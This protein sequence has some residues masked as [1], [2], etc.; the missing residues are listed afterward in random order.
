M[1][2][3]RYIKFLL[4]YLLIVLSVGCDSN[5]IPENVKE[6][7]TNLS[8]SSGFAISG[9]V[10]NK[11]GQIITDST[12]RILAD[13]RS[14]KSVRLNPDGKFFFQGLGKRTYNLIIEARNYKGIDKN[15]SLT[16]SLIHP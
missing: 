3:L 1:N 13:G 9:T 10:K 6:V 7:T 15:I 4:I 16:S 14:I 2:N 11:N 5:N 12:I 8:I